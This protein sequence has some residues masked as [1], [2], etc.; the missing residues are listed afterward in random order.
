MNNPSAEGK[1]ESDFFSNQ[2]LRSVHRLTP[3]KDAY[4]FLLKSYLLHPKSR[5]RNSKTIHC[6]PHCC[7]FLLYS[8]SLCIHFYMYFTILDIPRTLLSLGTNRNTDAICFRIYWS[9]M[10]SPLISVFSNKKVLHNT[11]EAI[12]RELNIS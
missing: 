1:Y 7:F 4:K 2:I 9:E 12:L 3:F 6:C 10:F 11:L 5:K 8:Y